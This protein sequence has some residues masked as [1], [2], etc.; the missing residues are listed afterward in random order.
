MSSPKPIS[1]HASYLRRAGQGAVG[2]QGPGGSAAVH[3][4]QPRAAHAQALPHL[5]M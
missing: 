4:L 5:R 2:G 3:V 1:G